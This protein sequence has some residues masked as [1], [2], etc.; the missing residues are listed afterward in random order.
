MEQE[1]VSHFANPQSRLAA[2]LK[3]FAALELK[4]GLIVEHG[5][6]QADKATEDVLV[7]FKAAV[8]GQTHVSTILNDRIDCL[9]K[10]GDI[11]ILRELVREINTEL[12][13]VVPN[14]LKEP[15]A[16]M[17]VSPR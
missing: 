3:E 8:Q 5:L 7:S 15:C 9:E 4:N 10:N 14:P 13:E 17:S 12:L 11:Q 2:E 16:R 6:S 1:N